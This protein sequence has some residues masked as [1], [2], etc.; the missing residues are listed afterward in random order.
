MTSNKLQA[1]A[2]RVPMTAG[3][4]P[5][6][7]WAPDLAALAFAF[8]QAAREARHAIDHMVV[9]ALQPARRVGPESLARRLWRGPLPT[10]R[11][12][13]DVEA[14]L[15]VLDREI[16]ARTHHEWEADENH[17]R[18]GW[19]ITHLEPDAMALARGA[20]A[21]RRLQSATDAYLDAVAA[22]VIIGRADDPE[23]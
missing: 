10:K 13:Q 22:D 15:H 23:A 1:D 20:N 3:A 2:D 21:L 8:A 5:T 17:V 9:P 11:L 18:G 16:E 6:V 7:G 14:L 4:V 12:A 19:P